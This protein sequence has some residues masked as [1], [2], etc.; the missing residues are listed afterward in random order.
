[1]SVNEKFIINLQGKSFVTYEGLLDLAHKNGLKSLETKIIQ[2][3]NKDNNMTAI[4]MAIA[5]TE[6]SKYQDIGDASPVS[7]NKALVPHLIRMAST[8]AKARVLRDLTNV[9]MTAVEELSE[10]NDLLV[11][12]REETIPSKQI[13]SPKQRET[14]TPRQIETLKKLSEQLNQEIN[15]DKLN[16]RSAANMIS[17]LIEQ[18]KTS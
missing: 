1:M 13:I 17:R 14:P 18:T 2:I 6:D 7:V 15:Y 5:T 9:G 12:E 10:E 3:P 16:K 8:R 11:G 4:C